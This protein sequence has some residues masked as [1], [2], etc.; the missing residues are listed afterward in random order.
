MAL[1]TWR[2][3]N[4]PFFGGST[5]VLAPQYDERLIKNDLMLLIMTVPG[6][7]RNRPDYGCRLRNFLF[8]RASRDQAEEIRNEILQAV[9]RWEPRVT[10]NS[11][12][13]V[14][15]SSQHRYDISMTFYLNNNPVQAL[16]VELRFSESGVTNAR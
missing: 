9:S 16:L 15:S 2:G 7:R 8:E 13:A 14:W 3:F 10:I 5:N 11:I 1:P 6:E 12:D 4:P